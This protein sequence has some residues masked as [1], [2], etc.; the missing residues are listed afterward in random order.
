MIKGAMKS[1]TIQFSL[2]L[3]VLGVLETQYRLLETFIPE[4][5]RGLV[6]I[7]IGMATAILRVVTT[8]ALSEK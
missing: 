2:A 7:G 6:F 1:K 8:E 4:E 5:Y 3:A